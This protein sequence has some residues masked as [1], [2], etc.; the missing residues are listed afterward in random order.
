M[1]KQDFIAKGRAAFAAGDFPFSMPVSWQERAFNEGWLDA[2]ESAS[3]AS[4]PGQDTPGVLSY[5]EAI[6]VFHGGKSRIAARLER[7][8]EAVLA[9]FERRQNRRKCAAATRRLE[10]RRRRHD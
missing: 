4:I 2:K 3:A 6:R 7:R 8:A 1:N 10:D 9:N 5:I